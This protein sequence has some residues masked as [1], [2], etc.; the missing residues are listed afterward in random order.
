MQDLI[1]EIFTLTAYQVNQV[2]EYIKDLKNPK[3]HRS[4]SQNAY[5]YKLVNEIAN[6][7]GVDNETVH[8]DLLKHYGQI[9]SVMML[10][11]INPRGYFKYYETD[12]IREV[13]GNKFTVYKVIKGSSQMNTDEMRILLQGTINE[14]ENVGIPTLTMNEIERLRLI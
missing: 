8:Y 9:T 6:K 3:K 14:A 7:T 10:S 13:N 5:F 4:L 2:A 11:N 1:N 12:A